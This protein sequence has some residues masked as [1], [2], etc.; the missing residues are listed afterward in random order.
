MIEVKR[1][2]TILYETTEKGEALRENFE[3]IN[4]KLTELE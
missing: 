1:G 2:N 4:S 3:Q